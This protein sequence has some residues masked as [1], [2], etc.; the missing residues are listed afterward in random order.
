M[1]AQL[2]TNGL[3]TIA[4][5]T[6]IADAVAVGFSW[7]LVDFQDNDTG[8]TI[9]VLVMFG[10]QEYARFSLTV[11]DATNSQVL[12]PNPATTSLFDQFVSMTTQVDGAYTA[13]ADAFWNGSGRKAD[14]L[15]A[16]ADVVDSLE[17]VSLDPP[18][19]AEPPIVAEPPILGG[20]AL[21]KA[22]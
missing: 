2:G 15:P 19:I 10:D 17:L 22:G 14:R 9:T 3:R 1:P 20:G 21:N 7:E 12:R 8:A 4:T 18:I 6:Q 13:L 16:V 5:P 11:A